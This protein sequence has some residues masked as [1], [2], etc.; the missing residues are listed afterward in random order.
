MKLGRDIT[1]FAHFVLDECLPPIVRDRRWFIWLP[2]RLLFRSKSDVF[3]RFK[4]IA[5]DMTSGAYRDAYKATAQVHIKRPTDLNKACMASV[6]TNARGDQVLEVGCGRGYLAARLA[7]TRRVTACDMVIDEQVVL[8]Y[9]SVDFREEHIES[10]S[11][12]DCAFDTVVCT[13]TLEHVVDLGRAVSELRR[14]TAHRL[15]VVVPKQRPYR[16]TFDLHLHFFP[17]RCM[18]LAWFRPD[19]RTLSSRLVELGGDWYYEEDRVVPN[20]DRAGCSR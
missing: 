1:R 18:L 6:L 12:Q 4:D 17:L 5:H 9:P 10:L 13:H 16:Y 15:I 20:S 2:F 14:V 19:S 8:R 3:V 7:A 11:F